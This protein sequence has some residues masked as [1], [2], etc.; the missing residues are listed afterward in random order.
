MVNIT[1]NEIQNFCS[2]GIF[3]ALR[4]LSLSIV[5]PDFFAFSANL[6]RLRMGLR[7]DEFN[8]GRHLLRVPAFLLYVTFL[9]ASLYVSKRGA[10]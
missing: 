10:Y 4:Y 1:T 8:H 3:L 7:T 2:F 5:N 9:S 6:S